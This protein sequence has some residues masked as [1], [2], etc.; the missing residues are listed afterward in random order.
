MPVATVFAVLSASPAVTALVPAT[1]ITPL[2]RE[3][4]MSVPAITLQRVS[5]VPTNNLVDD[6]GLD[7]NLVQIDYYGTDYTALKA[8]ADACRTA[9]ADH[10]MQSEIDGYEPGTDPELCQLTQTWSV[11]T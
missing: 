9:L 10:E 11:F 8:I 5:T 6:G 2:R 3:Q 4:G 1:Q 7:A